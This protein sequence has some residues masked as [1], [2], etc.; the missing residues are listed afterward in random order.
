MWACQSR[1]NWSSPYFDV[2][3]VKVANV[4]EDGRWVGPQAR[5]AKVAGRIQTDHDIHTVVICPEKNSD[6][7]RG[8]LDEVG[9]SCRP[10]SM[11]HLTR[12]LPELIRY[13]VFFL[14]EIVRLISILRDED[15]DIVHCN[16]PWQ[17][18]GL[19]AA[20]MAGIPAVWHLNDTQAHPGVRF[21]FNALAPLLATAFIAASHCAKTHYLDKGW[22]EEK[23][24]WIIQAPVDTDE[25]DPSHTQP[26]L[27]LGEYDG[28]KIATVG[29]VN[30][31][32]GFDV[33]VQAA[34]ILQA[35]SQSL[36]T[37]FF[38]VGP[39]YES[40]RDYGNR[41][42]EIVEEENLNVHFLGYRD[43][44]PEI[45]KASDIYVCSSNNEASPTAVWEA[46]AM[47][48]PVVSTKVGDV[49]RFLEGDKPCGIVV[50]PGD[51]AELANAISN[52]IKDRR[53]QKQYSKNAREV[54]MLELDLDVC[55]RRHAKVYHKLSKTEECAFL[56]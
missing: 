22:A 54:A 49:S 43:D 25:F 5:I 56:E 24:T 26:S 35:R 42:Q 1:L 53:K 48:L 7:L 34:N 16:G 23:P 37:H 45:L 8:R 39:I 21:I 41:L 55:V 46:M 30:P 14:P 52:L 19:I 50:P 29:S 12:H 20:K 47:G 17:I 2:S 9:V 4:T 32:K 15:V 28:L 31:R 40:Q 11:H 38:V 6:R 44:V 10:T 33:L 36:E 3:K 13:V 18:K 51:S 27:A